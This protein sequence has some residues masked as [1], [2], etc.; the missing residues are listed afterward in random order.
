MYLYIQAKRNSPPKR[1][2]LTDWLSLVGELFL[3][4]ACKLIGSGLG[5]VG[6]DFGVELVE[7]D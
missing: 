5:S 1:L 4:W 3:R 7:R 2:K 6:V